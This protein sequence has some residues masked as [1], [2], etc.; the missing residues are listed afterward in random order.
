VE[1]IIP[2][3]T[4][5][6][7][8]A[9]VRYYADVLGFHLDW[10]EGE[11]PTMASVSRDGHAIMLCEGD[12]G[13]PGTWVWI[14]VHEIEPLWEQ[15]RTRGVRFRRGPTRYPWAYEMQVEDPDGHVLRFGS[16]PPAESASPGS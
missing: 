8:P 5:A 16:E 14:G 12:Q 3:L 1:C 9:S 4:V 15:Y 7:V 13:H 10:E 6:S 2:I 11:P